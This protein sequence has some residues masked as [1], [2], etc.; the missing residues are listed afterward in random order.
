LEAEGSSITKASFRLDR[1]LENVALLLEPQ[2]KAKNIIPETTLPKITVS[3][4]EDLLKQVWINLLVNAIKFTPENGE[5]N[6]SLKQ[7]GETAVCIISD[8][9]IGIAPSEQMHIFERFYK[10]DKSRDRSLGGNG[11]GLALVKKI[12]NLH[13]GEVSVERWKVL[14]I[15]YPIPLLVHQ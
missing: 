9:G 15:L 1:Q 13:K 10:V 11:L 12:V 3:G 14:R 4:N 5:I 6:V 7:D 8:N 2:W